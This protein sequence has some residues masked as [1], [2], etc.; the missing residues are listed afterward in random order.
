MRLQP[1]GKRGEPAGTDCVWIGAFTSKKWTNLICSLLHSSLG[2]GALA[3]I[4]YFRC[5]LSS[6]KPYLLIIEGSLSKGGAPTQS[7]SCLCSGCT[8]K[9]AQQLLCHVKR[10]IFS[11]ALMEFPHVRVWGK[12]KNQINVLTGFQKCSYITILSEVVTYLLSNYVCCESISVPLW[13]LCGLFLTTAVHWRVE[14]QT[15]GTFSFVM[16]DLFSVI[17]KPRGRRHANSDEAEQ[18]LFRE[19]PRLDRKQSGPAAGGALVCC[20]IK[21]WVIFLFFFYLKNICFGKFCFSLGTVSGGSVA[22]VL[23][24]KEKGFVFNEPSNGKHEV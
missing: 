24:R 22:L 21:C 4:G 3:G 18:E 12:W 20:G 7:E 1:K 15:Q 11:Y 19:I 17:A 14:K 5:C 6:V 23:K 2:R 10:Y 13:F 9:A 8:Y 16:K